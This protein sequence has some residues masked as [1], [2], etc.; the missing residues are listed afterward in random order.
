[1]KHLSTLIASLFLFFA[2]S[3]V[4][5]AQQVGIFIGYE[6]IDQIEDDDEKAA[7]EWF[8]QNYS[9]GVIVTP[10]TLDK[11][12]DLST[13]WIPID[14]LG[15]SAGWKNLPNAYRS[16]D[17]IEAVTNH[18]KAGGSLY[19][20]THATQLVVGIGRVSDTYAPGI[21]GAGEGDMNSDVWG[22][23]AQIGCNPDL[24]NHYD[25]RSHSIY[26][27][28]ETNSDL[29]ADHEI[30]PLI[31]NGWKEDHNCKWDFNGIAGLEDNP[32]KLADFENKTNSSVIGAWQHV[33]DYACAGVVEFKPEGEYKGTVLCNGVAAYEFNEN[34]APNI[35]Q[36]NIN[37]LTKN[38]LDYLTSISKK[39]STGIKQVDSMVG[40]KEADVYYTVSGTRVAK[41]TAPGIYVV[42]HKKIVK[43]VQK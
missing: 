35:Y 12:G 8:Q 32:N 41:P 5:Y 36:D 6:S 37:L 22:I 11:I 33:T 42:N 18:V 15:I 43:G 13:L 34:D 27:N 25:H 30:Y 38:S 9:D 24:P 40:S 3:V 28:L 17:A 10:T 1:M 29:Y 23:N 21:F 31:G 16:T 20:T 7:A 2:G 26:K 39:V 19:L 14:R 4:S